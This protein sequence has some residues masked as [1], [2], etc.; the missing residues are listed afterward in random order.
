MTQPQQSQPQPLQDLALWLAFQHQMDQEALAAQTAAG[1]GI[2]FPILKFADLNGSTPPWLHAA[3]LELEKQFTKSVTLGTRFVQHSLWA[4]DPTAGQIPT[5]YIPFPA[6]S[7]RASMTVT[8]PAAIKHATRVLALNN[9]EM[10]A[11]IERQTMANAKTTSTGAGVKEATEGGREAVRQSTQLAEVVPESE[12]SSR[13]ERRVIGYARFTDSNPCYFCAMLASRGAVYK[14][15][16]FIE[17]SKHFGNNIAAVH[18]H[19]KCSLRP[20]F[21]TEDSMDER[22]KYFKAQW[23]KLTA[24]SSGKDAVKAFRRGYVP[25]PPYEDAPVVDLGNVRAN[26]ERLINLGF[27]EDSPQVQFYD[28]TIAKLNAS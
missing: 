19:C 26:R 21:R 28:D 4:I 17:V 15:D 8:G 23:D 13:R 27:G 25:P 16:S 9:E 22:A 1:L 10:T 11:G 7:V 14:Q 5:P 18:D 20:V 12:L 2:L 24:N 6:D 3:M